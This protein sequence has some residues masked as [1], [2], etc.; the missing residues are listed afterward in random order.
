MFF[1]LAEATATFRAVRSA[2]K[3]EGWSFN[4]RKCAEPCDFRDENAVAAS[5]GLVFSFLR[6]ACR[7]RSCK[8]ALNAMRLLSEGTKSDDDDDDDATGQIPR[9]KQQEEKKG[10]RVCGQN[11]KG[12][13][14]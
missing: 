6:W 13:R 8:I 10:E 2:H 12:E 14:A 7:S 1:V 9:T 3:I 11:E 4:G 5:G